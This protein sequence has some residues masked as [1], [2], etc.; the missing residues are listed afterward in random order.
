MRAWH[1]VVVVNIALMIGVGAGYLHWGR[2]AERLAAELAVARAAPP[3]PEREW[4][5]AG[6]VRAVMDDVG[7]LVVSHEDIP[8]YMRPMTMGFKT[9]DRALHDGLEVGD[10]IRFTLRGAPPR[11]RITAVE[12][13][14][15]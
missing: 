5:V 3:R 9:A 11:V 6:V 13:T 14:G 15:S 12:K 4:K 1:F 10:A 2:R 8:G 7:V